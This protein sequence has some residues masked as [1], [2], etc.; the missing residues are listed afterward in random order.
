[1]IADTVSFAAPAKINIHLKV[2]EKRSDGFHDIESIFQ[3]ISISDYISVMKCTDIAG[4]RVESPLTPL[5]AV[6]T[7]T[8]AWEVFRNAVHTDTGA[9]VRV[10]KNIPAGS[11]LGA[12]SSDAASLLQGLNVLF[13]ASLPQN[14]LLDMALQIGSDVPF[15]LGSAAAFVSGRG[16]LLTPIKARSDYFG[17]LICPD[18]H[19]S[20]KDAYNRLDA[21]MLDHSTEQPP[22]DIIVDYYKPA[23]E[24]QFYNDFQPVIE[25]EYSVV[26]SATM[27]LYAHGAVFAQMSGSGSSVFGLFK[28]EETMIAGFRCLSKK[29]IRCKPFLLLA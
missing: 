20:T 2:F 11:G 14:Q 16:E 24:W 25:A 8:K 3:R 22:A 12:G 28:T 23:E 19:V 26:K 13:K 18:V 1:M 21:G 4:C 15:F 10:L 5:P 7:L 29:W 9:W 17:I 6:N 27:D